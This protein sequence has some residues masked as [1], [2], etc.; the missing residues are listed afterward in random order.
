MGFFSDLVDMSPNRTVAQEIMDYC[1][2]TTLNDR[3]FNLVNSNS[4]DEQQFIWLRNSY[5][6]SVFQAF[7]VTMIGNYPN[8]Y[9]HITK[10]YLDE[11]IADVFYTNSAVE[12]LE[13]LGAPFPSSY[14]F[15]NDYFEDYLNRIQ[16]RNNIDIS[17]HLKEQLET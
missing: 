3:E 8:S 14:G 5:N 1:T 9:F 7:L 2:S 6:F 10:S 4:L 15:W 17:T 12:R 16:D 13:E 11:I